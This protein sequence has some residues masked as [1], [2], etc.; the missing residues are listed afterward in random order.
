[1]PRAAGALISSTSAFVQRSKQQLHLLCYSIFWF[2]FF[3]F[4][5]FVRRDT[6]LA[7]T[8]LQH[9]AAAGAVV[10][11]LSIT[12]VQSAPQLKQVDVSK[13][14]R[15]LHFVLTNFRSSANC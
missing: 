7:L 8:Q 4:S 5:L 12:L 2:I 6:M 1:V 11:L 10:L 3:G 15:L 9:F 13:F 14:M